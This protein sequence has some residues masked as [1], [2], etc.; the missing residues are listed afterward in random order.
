MVLVPPINPYVA[1]Q[2]ATQQV[3]PA[4]PPTAVVT[5]RPATPAEKR[6]KLRDRE[7]QHREAEQDVED[8][9]EARGKLTDVEA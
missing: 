3:K 4:T 7:K 9:V 5:A 6:E 1:S 2:L 8:E